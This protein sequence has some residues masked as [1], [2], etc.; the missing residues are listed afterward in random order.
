MS[1][2]ATRLRTYRAIGFGN[3]LRVLSYRLRLRARRFPAAPASGPSLPDGPMYAPPQLSPTGL[4]APRGW[5]DE[6]LLFSHHRFPVGAEPPD[7]LTDPF[8]GKAFPDPSRPWFAIADFDPGFGDIKLAWELSRFSWALPMAQRAREG[9]AD[10]LDR[11]NCWIDDWTARNLPYR[12]P[13]W[14]CAQEAGIRVM[15]V[16]MASLL[17]GHRDAGPRLA[18]WIEWHARRIAPTM[19][20]AR[21]QDNNHGTSEAAALFIGGAWLARSGHPEGKRWMT[22]GRKA[23]EERGLAL[24]ASDGSF[25]Q[26]SLTYHRMMLDTIS[27][28][29]LWRRAMDLPPFTPALVERAG[30]AADWLKAMIFS[31]DGDGPNL[32]AND[33][34]Q[35]LPLSD[36][37][38]RDFRPSCALAMTL[39]RDGAP[40]DDAGLNPARW[41]GL[42]TARAVN[43]GEPP[44]RLFDA[45]G[46]AILRQGRAVALLR[47]PRFAYRPSQND[48]LHV[49]LW[50]DGDAI[51]RDGGTYSYNDGDEWIDYFGGIAGHNSIQFDGREPMPRLGRFLL[52]DWLDASGVA[53]GTDADGFP[54]A[55]ATYRDRMGA[56]HRRSVTLRPDEAI[57][58][59]DVSGFAHSATIRWR[60]RPGDWQGTRGGVTAEGISLRL[61]G[62]FG[63]EPRLE[64]GHESLFYREMHDAPVL[65]ATVR[66]AGTITS[67][68]RWAP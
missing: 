59:D 20:Y 39:F 23:L 28:A 56:V 52:G 10:E 38:Y 42:D 24:I 17:L 62:D 63:D 1:R 29:E 40:F 55:S 5:I 60:L 65:T 33:G 7:W 14:K 43:S 30:R 35:L 9:D 22:K 27:M 2:I 4:S 58:V 34:A 12:G 8:T 15:H 37:P 61:E 64:A 54:I 16:A 46:Y 21:A 31:P 25:S 44:H 53:T 26:H 51:L 50:V 32:G 49:D 3:I 18:Q 67:R 48:V 11:L 41:F 68:L 45:G 6:G 66:S 36:T 19:A 47:F 57:I 13:N